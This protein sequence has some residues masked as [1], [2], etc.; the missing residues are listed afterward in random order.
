MN[1]Y[2]KRL[3]DSILARHKEMK[4]PAIHRNSKEIP[5]CK[6]CDQKANI[7]DRGIGGYTIQ[8]SISGELK[9]AVSICFQCCN[10]LRETFDKAFLAIFLTEKGRN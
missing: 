4:S 3:S 6:F 9:D 8:V 2:E 10:T 7:A 5:N 1:E